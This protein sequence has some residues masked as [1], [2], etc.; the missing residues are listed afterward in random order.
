[1]VAKLSTHYGHHVGDLGALHKFNRLAIAGGTSFATIL[2]RDIYHANCSESSRSKLYR[3]KEIDSGFIAV[4]LNF[5]CGLHTR[6]NTVY[7]Y[8]VGKFKCCHYGIKIL[9]EEP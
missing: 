3:E 1:M 6:Y 2:I 5:P 4:R 8:A 9:Q 7:S